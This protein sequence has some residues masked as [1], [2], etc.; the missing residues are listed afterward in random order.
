VK[1]ITENRLLLMIILPVLAIGI[2]ISI[3]LQAYLSPKMFAIISSRNDV[4][5]DKAIHTAV[6]V[7]EERFNDLL[8]LRMTSNMEMRIASLKQAIEEIKAIHHDTTD[9]HMLVLSKHGQILGSTLTL[10]QIDTEQLLAD[11]RLDDRIRTVSL[12]QQRYKMTYRYFPFWKIHIF[13]MISNTDYMA[14][15]I[16]AKRIVYLGTFGVLLTVLVVLVLLF[17]LRVNRPLKT[18]IKAT[19]SVQT[20]APH[21]IAVKRQDEIGKL[22]S[23]FNAMVENLIEDKRQIREMMREL[24]DSEEQYRILSEYSLTH[25]AMIQKGRLKFLNQTM[26]Q[27]VGLDAQSV[28][29][30]AFADLIDSQDRP[31]IIERLAALESGTRKT[32][33]F[34]CRLKHCDGTVI[35]LEALATL[36]L[37]RETHAVLFHAVNITARKGLEKR[38][39][40]AQKLEAIGTLAGGVA[41]DL[42]NILSSL[43]GYPELLLL[44]LPQESPLR[45]PLTNIQLSAQRAAEVVQDL[46]AMA[47]RGV[48]VRQVLNLNRIIEDYLLSIEHS[49]I[50]ELHPGIVFET[51]L[52][53]YL[54]NMQ[55]S[56]IHLTK[57]LMNLVRNAAE[58]IPDNGR[59]VISS[60]NH[61][62]ESANNED[63]D[64]PEG[65]YVVLT[66]QDDGFGISKEDIE[67]IFEPFYTKKVMGHSGTGLGM[68]V[69]LGTV[70]DHQGKVEVSSQEGAGTQFTLYFPATRETPTQQVCTIPFEDYNGNGEKILV[71]DDIEEQRKLMI[72]MLS[73]FGYDTV[74]VDS[75]EAAVAFTKNEHADLIL[76]DMVMEPGIDGLETFRQIRVNAPDQKAIILSGYSDTE[77]VQAALN[78]GADDYLKKPVIMERLGL[79]VRNALCPEKA[80]KQF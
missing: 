27:A 52:D 69:V 59:V 56:S 10:P 57:S 29:P 4:L 75:G 32:D 40:Q 43:L 47:R 22:S 73:R 55:G 34:E 37:Y 58:S 26:A 44:D 7:C 62:V 41:H 16:L 77:R 64:I 19:Q 28:Q 71:V 51:K 39:S 68:S 46:L 9:I 76:L 72:E 17:T 49:K 5:L 65:D 60:A 74:A 48:D 30:V 8:D 11:R 14:P 18:L 38:L 24:R 70:Q 67:R 54:L 33:H 66:V 80:G 3:L 20:E 13:G 53:N 21:K 79:A 45:Q 25:I 50:C 78:M 12:S 31:M 35:W 15:L 63:Q 6:S 1:L 2:A 42:N 23:A 36:A 61:Y